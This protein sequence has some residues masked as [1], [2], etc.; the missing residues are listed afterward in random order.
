MEHKTL[1]LLESLGVITLAS[2]RAHVGSLSG[3][4]R[5]SV[6]IARSL[7]GEPRVAIL[8]EPTAALGVVQTG[9]VLQLIG[10]LRGRGLAVVV[11]SHN[12]EEI[13]E[14]R[15]P[16]DPS[17]RRRRRDHGR[18]GIGL[19]AA[20]AIRAI[21]SPL[22]QTGVKPWTLAPCARTRSVSASLL[23]ARN[24]TLHCTGW[25]S[26]HRTSQIR[27][28]L[29]VIFSAPFLGHVPRPFRPRHAP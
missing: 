12:R 14:L 21:R 19:T 20:S 29:G 11:I 25:T 28:T 10:R 26:A 9:Q 16:H 7:L 15:P 8:D 2:V 27:G 3:G 24:A 4:Q 22:Y 18:H 23:D 13:G 1:E 5:Q 17:G 6:A